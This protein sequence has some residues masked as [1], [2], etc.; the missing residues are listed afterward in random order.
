METDDRVAGNRKTG[1]TAT[2]AKGTGA[3]KIIC[4]REAGNP[5]QVRSD[6]DILYT[7]H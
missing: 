7:S 6:G 5:K 1:D 2:D 4:N 3:R